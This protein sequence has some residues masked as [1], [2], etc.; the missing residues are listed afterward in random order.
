MI[1]RVVLWLAVTGDRVHDTADP[2]A[3]VRPAKPEE[4]LNSVTQKSL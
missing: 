1:E 3:V 4:N 2:S